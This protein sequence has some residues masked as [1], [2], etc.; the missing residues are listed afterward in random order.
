MQS[1]ASRCSLGVTLLE[2]AERNSRCS[3]SPASSISSYSISKSSKLSETSLGSLFLSNCRRTLEQIRLSQT[4]GHQRIQ[5]LLLTA[6]DHLALQIPLD[7]NQ[8]LENKTSAISSRGELSRS[9]S[10]FC[11]FPKLSLAAIQESRSGFFAC[12]FCLTRVSER[13]F[14]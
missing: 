1:L 5:K 12:I 6:A 10:A 4:I 3:S 7:S 14:S 11:L 13:S 8:F 2:A 9:V